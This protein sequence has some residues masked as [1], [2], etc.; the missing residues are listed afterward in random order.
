MISWVRV[1]TK[2]ADD[3]SVARIAAE[4][5]VKM[6]HAVGLV[7]AVLCQLP[8]HAKDGQ[9]AQVPDS[10][11]ERWAGWD[12]KAGR[13]AT[14]FRRELCDAE[15]TVRSWERYNGAPIREAEADLQRKR[16]S[17]RTRAG[18]SGERPADT[19]RT[20]RRTK[21]RPSGGSP[22]LRDETNYGEGNSAP[23][24]AESSLPHVRVGEETVSAALAL[25]GARADGPRTHRGMERLG[26]IMRRELAH[27]AA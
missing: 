4:L 3:P 23:H 12:G 11:I 25:E 26:E 13:F 27:G 16:E 22:P 7:V 8:D 17:R 19:S 14:S 18:A 21:P 9:L 5:R 24:G 10:L 1:S 2:I 6:P 15:G 20:V